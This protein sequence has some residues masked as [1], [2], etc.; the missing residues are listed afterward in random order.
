EMVLGRDHRLTACSTA[1]G[2]ALEGAGITCGM[3]GSAGAVS[4]AF[5][6]GNTWE[7]EVIGGGR[8]SGI[9]GSGLIDICAGLLADGQ[10]DETGAFDDRIEELYGAGGDVVIA[11][12]GKT[13]SGEPIVITQK[14]IRQLQLAKGAIAAGIRLLASDS[15]IRTEDIKEVLLAGAFGSFLSPDSACDIGM[16]PEELRGRIT[17]IGNAAGEGAK[18]VLRNKAAWKEASETA[19]EARF[20]ELASLPEFQDQ[21]VENLL[22]PEQDDSC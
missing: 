2:P 8:P 9:C 14:D 7:Y 12:A 15:G 3:R 19:S 1:A 11:D 16:I 18:A 6:S 13:L 5:R 20:L 17:A 4:H 21:F 22:F 10:M